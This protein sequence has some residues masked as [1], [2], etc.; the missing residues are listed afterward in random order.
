V[1][2]CSISRLK[3]YSTVLNPS[4]NAVGSRLR[5]ESPGQQIQTS[6]NGRYTLYAVSGDDELGVLHECPVSSS[7]V[8]VLQNV[9]AIELA[10][11]PIEVPLHWFL[12]DA[13][14]SLPVTSVSRQRLRHPLSARAD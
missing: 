13:Q 11:M 10:H 9:Q 14:H 6:V 1:R 2:S 7:G 4:I 12:M 5:E 8:E 3:W